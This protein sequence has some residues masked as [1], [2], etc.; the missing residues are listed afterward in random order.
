MCSDQL[1]GSV[2]SG[3]IEVWETGEIEARHGGA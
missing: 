3:E 1:F 2:G